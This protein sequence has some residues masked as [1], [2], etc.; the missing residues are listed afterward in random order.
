MYPGLDPD[1]FHRFLG[2]G[3][4]QEGKVNFYGELPEY[5]SSETWEQG[6]GT[7]TQPWEIA[8]QLTIYCLLCST[9]SIGTLFNNR[10]VSPLYM[11]TSRPVGLLWCKPVGLHCSVG[12]P[13]PP[14]YNCHFHTSPLLFTRPYAIVSL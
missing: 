4:A 2:T 7:Q 14:S 6:L 3:Q 8:N 12:T 9:H 10:A 1:Q 13:K 11:C 5:P